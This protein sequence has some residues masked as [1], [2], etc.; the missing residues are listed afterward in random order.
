MCE[1][2]T[3]CRMVPKSRQ[4][5]HQSPAHPKRVVALTLK[6]AEDEGRNSQ[7]NLEGLIANSGWP[8]TGQ[9]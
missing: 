8:P 1:C 3:R 7:R 9:M 5:N 6:E 4:S 2:T